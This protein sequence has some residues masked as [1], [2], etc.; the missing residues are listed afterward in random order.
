MSG[1]AV[2]PAPLVT[3][4]IPTYNRAST[5]LPCTLASAC[6]QMYPRLE[7]LVSDNA[8]N[9]ATREIVRAFR[10]PRIR[11]HRH[12]SNIG[13]SN[14]MN[15]CV[16]Q[17]RGDYL[18][19]LPDDDLLDPDFVES[20][21]NLAVENPLAGLI[22]TGTRVIDAAGRVIREAPNGAVGLPFDE[23]VR[24]WIECKTSPYQCSTMFRTALL[25]RIGLHSRRHLFDDVISFFKIAAAHG[26]AGTHAIK[27]SYRLHEGELTTTTS[28]RAWCD[29]SL[30]LLNLLCVLSPGDSHDLRARGLRFLALGNY[31][32]AFRQPL[33]ARLLGCV[34]VFRTHGFALPP[35]P[36]VAQRIAGRLRRLVRV[37]RPRDRAAAVC[38]ARR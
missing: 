23:L 11:Y 21:A 17:A 1:P 13:S 37:L 27:A 34:T 14:N 7:I 33:P 29:E 15:F 24:A 3:I 8:S 30:D 4:A 18:V 22:W 16:Q 12:A 20:C 35:N 28:I 32:R 25:Q 38:N 2:N 19:L 6:A 10:D 9:D 26:C 36:A 31:R 5:F